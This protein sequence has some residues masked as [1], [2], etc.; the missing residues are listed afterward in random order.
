MPSTDGRTS[1]SLPSAERYG[2]QSVSKA[3]RVTTSGVALT[4]LAPDTAPRVLFVTLERNM[5]NQLP[6]AEQYGVRTIGNA[7]DE[8]RDE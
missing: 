8:W 6:S 3:V 4:Y 5:N 1:N 7:V 2:A